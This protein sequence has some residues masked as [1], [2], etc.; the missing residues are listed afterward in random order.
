MSPIT[1]NKAGQI[2]AGI[3]ESISNGCFDE[4]EDARQAET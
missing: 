4:L 2:I 3:V 1:V